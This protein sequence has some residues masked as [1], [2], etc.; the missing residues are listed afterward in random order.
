MALN[1]FSIPAMSSEIERGFSPAQLLLTA[2]RQQLSNVTIQEVE[3]LQ[4]WWQQ[5]IDDDNVHHFLNRL[6]PPSEYLIGYP[7]ASTF[8]DFLLT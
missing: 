3:L 5:G 2:Q 1:L 7:R 6:E 8:E 4:H